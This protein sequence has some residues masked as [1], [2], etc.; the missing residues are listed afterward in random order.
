MSDIFFSIN[1][2]VTSMFPQFIIAVV[3]PALLLGLA[4][5]YIKRLR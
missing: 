1:A 3:F 2:I 4:F 5:N